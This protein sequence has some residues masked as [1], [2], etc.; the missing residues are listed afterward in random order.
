MAVQFQSRVFSLPKSI[1]FGATV[2]NK[3]LA[4][5]GTVH[6]Y[7]DVVIVSGARTAFA[8]MNGSFK[9]V[10]ATDMLAT[11]MKGALQKSGLAATEVNQVIMGNVI[12]NDEHKAF[13]HRGVA[14]EVGLREETT[15]VE[16]N[17]LCGTGIEVMRQAASELANGGDSFILTGGVENMTRTPVMDNTF[18][19]DGMALGKQA[20][21]LGEKFEAIQKDQ[22]ELAKYMLMFDS[23][24]RKE[25]LKAI[26]WLLTHP[27]EKAIAQEFAK[28][29]GKL[30]KAQKALE[31]RKP[32]TTN[33]LQDG[34]TDPRVGM[35]M[36]QTADRL[37]TLKGLSVDEINEFAARSQRLA[38]E[39]QAAGRFDE[40]IVPLTTSDLTDK[41]KLP[42]GVT[43]VS[44]DEHLRPGT[45]ATKLARLKVLDQNNK[46]A[47]H[48]AGTSSGVV[49][50]AA[51]LLMSTG[52]LAA[53]KNLPILAKLKSISVTG[54]DPKIMGFGP[55]RAAQEAMKA[56]NITLDQVDILE[57][58]EAF[59][60]QTLA[61][62]KALAKDAG[63][64]F[65]Q[66]L[67]KL[68]PDG[69]AIALGH[70]L[71]ASGS[72]ITLHTALKL[73][74]ENKRYAVV[75]ACIGG[76][77]GIAAVIENPD[78]KPE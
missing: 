32:H 53:E 12:A 77:Q 14:L 6:A 58:N 45:T 63:Y 25:K 2:Q 23:K 62:A 7:D 19:T 3:A 67:P 22:P 65:N 5:G 26:A 54:C 38:G 37:A 9:D 20:A 13:T 39:A 57:I 76:G 49:D 30:L 47:I 75:S 16:G 59:S 21:A 66:L 1:Q 33:P 72:R 28:E 50:G 68:N 35:V 73:K 60:G 48:T 41:S 70:P 40:E 11:A 36:F 8:K 31:A 43:S 4:E 64:D 78:Y 42:D 51:A 61:V 15:A 44:K 74:A 34:L 56:A 18:V 29:K 24:N 27:K 46:D 10:S 71:S 55:V 17:R 69:G 52:K